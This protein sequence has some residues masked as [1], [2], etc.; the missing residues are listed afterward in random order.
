MRQSRFEEAYSPQWAELTRILDDLPGRDLSDTRKGELEEAPRLYR[1]V[2]NHYSLAL[3]RRYTSGLAGQLHSLVLQGHRR[4]HRNRGQSLHEVLAFFHTVFPRR[5]REAW[6]YT[7]ASL[8]FFLVPALLTACW[9][10]R[11]PTAIYAVMS[12]MQVERIE[13]A[14]HKQR[15]RSAEQD[16]AMF[17]HYIQ[18]NVSI[19]FRTFAGGLFFGAGAL[20]V[21][22]Y[23]GVFMGGVSGHLSHPPFGEHYW[24]FVI[25]HAPLELTAMLLAG[26]AGLMLG[27]TLLRP[28][29][30]RRLDALR[31]AATPA[32]QIRLGAALMTSLAAVIE[33]FWSAQTLPMSVKI[34]F[35]ALNWAAIL[36]YFAFCGRPRH[37]A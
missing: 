16:I 34:G 8:L 23:N 17:G 25:G 19:D 26:A 37:A 10:Y 29:P 32:M 28:G 7:L 4:I 24:A 3:R 11:E 5:V 15:T 18:N 6:A 31:L 2:C 13:Q 33:A 36:A 1:R 21:L 27:M 14:Y 30:W 22:V 35:S 9:T 12:P 20:L